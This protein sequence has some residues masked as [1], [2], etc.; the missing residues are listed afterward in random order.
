MAAFTGNTTALCSKRVRATRTGVAATASNTIKLVPV[1]QTTA[2]KMSSMTVKQGKYVSFVPAPIEFPK[3]TIVVGSDPRPGS[4]VDVIVGV[5]TLGA[6]HA[7]LEMLEEGIKVTALAGEGCFVDG[8][9]VSSAELSDGQVLSFD[10]KKGVSYKAVV[11][12]AGAGM[13]FDAPLEDRVEDRTA[14]IAAYNERMASGAGG[15][16]G[17]YSDAEL[18]DRLADRIAWINAY[19]KEMETA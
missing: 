12:A 16:K 8:K 5:S 15:S 9:A 11:K 1:P 7:K 19:K 13:M 18:A 10:L 14:W 3:D 17:M 6:T 4:D 2:Q